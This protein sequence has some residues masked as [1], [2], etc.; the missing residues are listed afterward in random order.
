LCERT[1]DIEQMLLAALA[2]DSKRARCARRA[3]ILL[4]FHLA[5]SSARFAESSM[6]RAHK[7]RRTDPA[8]AAASGSK[9]A[10]VIPGM[11]FAS[12]TV[13]SPSSGKSTST[14]E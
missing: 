2:R 14:R 12:R 13:G 9:L 8:R 10:S 11:V 4:R 6:I 1:F 3:L 5:A 7:L